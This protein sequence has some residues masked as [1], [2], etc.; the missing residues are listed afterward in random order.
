MRKRI[1]LAVVALIALALVLALFW[2]ARE[3]ST[4]DT[5]TRATAPT[6]APS[7][8]SS[9]SAPSAIAP[10]TPA[11]PELPAP[12]DDSAYPVN[13]EELRRRLPDNMYW[14]LGA[15]TE[16]AD[17]L[18]LRSERARQSN[19]LYGK[20]LSTTASEEEIRRYYAERRRVSEDYIEFAELV[21]SEYREE[22]PEE[23]IGM[24]ELSI[25]L[26]RARLVEIPR[27]QDEALARRR[28]KLAR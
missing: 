2:H 5:T 27:D 21:L 16:D 25:R 7:P 12:A 15:P 13:L 28:A 18:R 14:T 19:E 11:L 4:S 9:A 1:A 22:L 23:H 20:V 10:A 6:S 24:Y 8:S 26:H 17:T 3:P